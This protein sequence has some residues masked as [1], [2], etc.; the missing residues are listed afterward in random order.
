M[1]FSPAEIFASE[2]ERQPKCLKLLL[3]LESLRLHR[4]LSFHELILHRVVVLLGDVTRGQGLLELLLLNSLVNELLLHV[5]NTCL[6]LRLHVQKVQFPSKVLCLHSFI[7]V[8][9]YQVLVQSFL[10]ALQVK[11]TK[12]LRNLYDLEALIFFFFFF[13]IV[14]VTFAQVNRTPACVRCSFLYIFIIIFS[15]S[16]PTNRDIGRR[17][18]CFSFKLDSINS[19]VSFSLILFEVFVVSPLF[20]SFERQTLV[21]RLYASFE[22]ESIY[23]DGLLRLVVFWPLVRSSKP[24]GHPWRFSRLLLS[25]SHCFA[26]INRGSVINLPVFS[27]ACRGSVVVF[28]HIVTSFHLGST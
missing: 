16:T 8:R 14:I 7:V 11:Q 17:N 13:V 6:H 20:W 25:F 3:L 1:E 4:R 23:L 18:I 28:D 27:R 5:D 21:V 2:G 9:T 26:H 12:G 19:D 15:T 10:A 24:Q 22:P